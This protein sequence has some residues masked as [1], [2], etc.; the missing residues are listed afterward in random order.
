MCNGLTAYEKKKGYVTVLHVYVTC[1]TLHNE[2]QFITCYPV[3]GVIMQNI[4][5]VFYDC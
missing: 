4:F 2:L 1:L 5:P 3:R